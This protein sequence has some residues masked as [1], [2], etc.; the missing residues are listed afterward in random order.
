MDTEVICGSR[1]WRT[2][3]AFTK[4]K[5]VEECDPYCSIGARRNEA[6]MRCLN[7]EHNTN[8][9]HYF[10]NDKIDSIQ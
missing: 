1:V 4:V 6:A 9:L 5:A 8:K 2:K 10:E 3:H 7:P